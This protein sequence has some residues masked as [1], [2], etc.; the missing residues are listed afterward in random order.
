[1]ILKNSKLTPGNYLKYNKFVLDEKI[2][3]NDDLILNLEKL[4]KLNKLKKDIDY[5]N[6]AIY[7]IESILF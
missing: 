7:L 2:N 3:I 4:L 1:M 5:L 6:F